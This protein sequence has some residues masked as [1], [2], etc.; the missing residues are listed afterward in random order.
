MIKIEERKFDF[1][2]YPVILY[3]D[4]SLYKPEPSQ[5]DEYKDQVRQIYNELSVEHS[6]GNKPATIIEANTGYKTFSLDTHQGREV[7]LMVE[8]DDCDLISSLLD[9]IGAL[10]QSAIRESEIDEVATEVQ[11]MLKGKFVP[12]PYKRGKGPGKWGNP[13]EYLEQIYGPYLAKFNESG[14][15][16]LYQF[17]LKSIDANF[18]NTLLTWLR[19][20]TNLDGK[21][22]SYWI[23]TKQDF[24][25]KEAHE[26]SPSIH[27]QAIAAN[28]TRLKKNKSRHS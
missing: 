27:E 18:R 8:D 10:V 28:I 20:Q 22:L 3:P 15:N 19:R 17:Q 23:P 12:L 16:Y 11:L 24:L 5:K 26:F 25:K 9:Q 6:S 7:V 14:N 21:T 2:G 13:L 4:E 1:S